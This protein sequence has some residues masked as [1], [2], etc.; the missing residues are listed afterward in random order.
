MDVG[1]AHRGR[2]SWAVGYT[3][4]GV[5]ASRYGAR[6]AL[7]LLDRPNVPALQMRFVRKRALP[8]PPEPIRALGVAMTQ[9]AMARADRNEGR[10]GPWLKLL[11]AL[12]VGFDS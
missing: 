3:G 9:R 8:W 7:D 11:D 6:V 12:G 1:T 10:R 4:L 5:V 2:V